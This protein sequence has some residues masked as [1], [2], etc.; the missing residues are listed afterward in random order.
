[1]AWTRFLRLRSLWQ[2][3]RSNPGQTMTLHT[4]TPYPMSLPNINFPHLVVSEILP[5]QDFQGQG[6]YGKVKGQIKVKL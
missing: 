2:G 5:G 6:H 3:E 4:Y 1:M